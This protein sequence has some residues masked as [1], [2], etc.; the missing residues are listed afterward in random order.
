[1]NLKWEIDKKTYLG[2]GKCVFNENNSITK[3]IENFFI[4]EGIKKPNCKFYYFK[5]RNEFIQKLD[6]NKPISQI[7][8]GQG[9]TIFMTNKIQNIK[10]PDN[11]LINIKI[12]NRDKFINIDTNK[13]RS[14]LSNIKSEGIIIDSSK[15]INVTKSNVFRNDFTFEEEKKQ[16]K[17][18]KYIA[19]IIIVI[20]VFAIVGILIPYFIYRF[21]L[22]NNPLKDEEND[23]VGENYKKEILKANII[24]RP[25]DIYLFKTVE[26]TILTTEGE[27]VDPRNSVNNISEYKYYLLMIEKEYKEI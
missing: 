21:Y 11:N 26:N 23:I 17:K 22:D 4:T 27:K 18:K 24:Y 14:T 25:G 6:P 13:D 1:M 10:K 2:S 5:K 3:D 20:I 15:S 9:N 16:N 12:Y 8:K 19:I 7:E